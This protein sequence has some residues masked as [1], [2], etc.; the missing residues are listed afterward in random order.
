[1]WVGIGSSSDKSSMANY[2]AFETARENI[3]DIILSLTQALEH[4]SV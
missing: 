3:S 4:Y 1:M 2:Q